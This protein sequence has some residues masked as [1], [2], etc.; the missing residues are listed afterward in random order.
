MSNAQKALYAQISAMGAPAAQQLSTNDGTGLDYAAGLN[1]GNSKNVFTRQDFVQDV[2]DY[3]YERDGKTFNTVDEA[4][5][6]FM[7]D[8]RWRN[9]NL[10]SIGRD[11]YDANTQNDEQTTRL[12]RLQTTFDAMP[13]FY[14]D[15]G[16]GWQ[17]FGTNALATLADPINL[18]GFGSG[19]IAAREAAKQVIAKGGRTALT[20]A[21]AASMKKTAT[22][23]ALKSGVYKGAL[24]EG[25]ASGVAEG[26]LDAGIQ[27]RNTELG[28]QDGYSLTQG[29]MA[30]GGG[31]L[32]GGG[33]GAVLGGVAAVAPNPFAKGRSATEMGMIDGRS[34]ARA[35]VRAD[36]EVDEL[37]PPVVAP[38]AELTE[39]QQ[40]TQRLVDQQAAV[41][42][43]TSGT[44]GA[45]A[46]SADDLDPDTPTADGRMSGS[47]VDALDLGEEDVLDLAAQQAVNLD[48]LAS[49]LDAE[50]LKETKNLDKVNGLNE[51]AR[52]MRNA[53]SNISNRLQK[54]LSDDEIT[55]PDVIQEI[56][57][58]TDQTNKD[59]KLIGYDS[60]AAQPTGNDGGGTVRNKT[61]QEKVDD[62]IDTNNEGA[63]PG[64]GGLLSGDE[65]ADFSDPQGFNSNGTLAGRGQSV[66]GD[67][68]EG[69]PDNKMGPQR[70]DQDLNN[71]DAEF[72]E[73][74]K[75]NQGRKNAM[76]DAVAAQEAVIENK[77]GSLFTKSE[78][79]MEGVDRS[80][81]VDDAEMSSV[82]DGGGLKPDTPPEVRKRFRDKFAGTDQTEEDVVPILVESRQRLMAEQNSLRDEIAK[83]QAILDELKQR[84]L[85]N[86]K[87]IDTETSDYQIKRDEA[88]AARA[89]AEENEAISFAAQRVEAEEIEGQRQAD[90]ANPVKVFEAFKGNNDVLEYLESI[91]ISDAEIAAYK[92]VDGRTAAK[93]E[94]F[95]EVFYRRM[96]EA[97]LG[98]ILHDLTNGEGVINA[99]FNTDNIPNTDKSFLELHLEGASPE[100]IKA[101][102]D[103]QE[104]MLS[105]PDLHT[106]KITEIMEGEVPEGEGGFFTAASN[107]YGPTFARRLTQRMKDIADA[108][109]SDETMP[110]PQRQMASPSGE[111][112]WG[113]NVK[114]GARALASGNF[115]TEGLSDTDGRFAHF[116][117]LLDDTLN[118]ELLNFK[119]YLLQR[120]LDEG[121]DQ[122]KAEKIASALYYEKLDKMAAGRDGFVERNEAML[123]GRIREI[124]D[125][126]ADLRTA[127]EAYVGSYAKLPVKYRSSLTQE[128]G[129]IM[130]R[131]ADG[132]L[133]E[134]ETFRYNLTKGQQPSSAEQKLI[135]AHYVN[136]A[137]LREV[138]GRYAKTSNAK[139][140]MKGR[141]DIPIGD[142]IVAA[143]TEISRLNAKKDGTIKIVSRGMRLTKDTSVHEDTGLADYMGR[144][145]IRDGQGIY[146]PNGKIQGILKKVGAKGFSG[147]L[148]RTGYKKDAKGQW[149]KQL[150]GYAHLDEMNRA[151]IE[152]GTQVRMRDE[153]Q[154]VRNKDRIQILDYH[155]ELIDSLQRAVSTLRNKDG[156]ATYKFKATKSKDDKG[157]KITLTEAED[158]L[159][160]ASQY[161]RNNIAEV[162]AIN[163]SQSKTL[164]GGLKGERTDLQSSTEQ[165]KFANEVEVDSQNRGA[166]LIKKANREISNRYAALLKQ[167]AG[168]KAVGKSLTRDDIDYMN[169]LFSMREQAN[170][171]TAH[172]QRAGTEV[173]Q[174][175]ANAIYMHAFTKQGKQRAARRRYLAEVKDGMY[176]YENSTYGEQDP[177]YEV[178]VSNEAAAI[179]FNERSNGKD[180]L[181]A[182]GNA[183]YDYLYGSEPTPDQRQQVN[184]QVNQLALTQA[185]KQEM[186]EANKT[187]M[188]RAQNGELT[189]AELLDAMA[190][191]NQQVQDLSIVKEAPTKPVGVKRQPLIATTPSGVEVD[192]NNDI[193]Y[194]R[195][196]ADGAIRLEIDGKELGRFSVAKNGNASIQHPDGFK[197][198]F[199]TA[200]D[201]K[202]NLVRI[203]NRQIE[204][205]QLQSKG[206]RFAVKKSA[207]GA[208][209][210][211]VD[212]TKTETYKNETPTKAET[213]DS[214]PEENPPVKNDP[215]NVLTWTAADFDDLPDGRQL[216][217]Q[218]LDVG[219]KVKKAGIVR[220]A[221]MKGT[222][223]SRQPQNIGD[224]LGLS[225]DVKYVIGHVQAGG[226]RSTAQETFFPM[227]L[228]DVFL[229]QN[230]NGL[231]GHDVPKGKRGMSA[232]VQSNRKRENRASKLED[233]Q[234]NELKLTD[235]DRDFFKRQG[236]ELNFVGDLVNYVERI[237]TLDWQGDIKTLAGLKRYATAR[238]AAARV[239][240]SN[241]PNG[242]KKPT[243][244][245]GFA[246]NKLRSMFDGYPQREVQTAVDFLERMAAYNGGR[247]PVLVKSTDG[248]AFDPNT[249]AIKVDVGSKDATKERSSPMA[250]ELVHEMG[251]W[252]YDNLLDEGDRQKFWSSMEKFYDDNGALDF[253]M[254][255]R[256]MVDK[257]LISNA[258]TNPQEFFANQFLGYVLQTDALRVPGSKLSEVFHKVSKLGKALFDY[259]MGRK[260]MSVDADLAD[261]FKK[262]L[263]EEEI[264]PLTGA[265]TR[266]LSKF[267]GLEQMGIEHG[268]DAQFSYG[269]DVM[270]AAQFAARQMVALDERIRDLQISKMASPRGLGD[271]FALAI[272]LEKIAK[273]LY[274]EYGGVKGEA[275]HKAIPGNPESG[276]ARI[277]ALDY[278]RSKT[279]GKTILEDVM[280]A[281]Y[282]IHGFLKRLRSE[283]ADSKVGQ[284]LSGQN[285]TDAAQAEAINREMTTDTARD[286]QSLYERMLTQSKSAYEGLDEAVVDQLHA[287]S[288]DL[289]VAMQRA[290]G[291]Y[292]GMFKRTMPRTERKKIAI[293]Q[294]TGAAYVET[295]PPKSAMFRNAAI[296][297]NRKVMAIEQSVSE[298]VEELSKRGID[299][300]DV[301]EDAI[302]ADAN[303]RSKNLI[304]AEEL[305]NAL[306]NADL[307]EGADNMGALAQAINELKTRVTFTT[308]D[309]SKELA[310]LEADDSPL[311][312]ILR[313]NDEALR[314]KTMAALEADPSDFNLALLDYGR[315]H[316]ATVPDAPDPISTDPLNPAI[317]TFADRISVR[318]MDKTE[319]GI[320]R[321]LF[322]KLVR[323]IKGA[324][325][326]Q[327]ILD[328]SAE[329]IN[330]F[331]LAILRGD[332]LA[333]EYSDETVVLPQGENYDEA[334]RS[335]RGMAKEITKINELRNVYI[336]ILDSKG[337][338]AEVAPHR[339]A[340]FDSLYNITFAM[341]SRDEQ[342]GIMSLEKADK[343]NLK[344]KFSRL[345][346]KSVDSVFV[347]VA[348][349]TEE[350]ASADMPYLFQTAQTEA[351]QFQIDDAVQI[352]DGMLLQP[353]S[354]KE[355]KMEVRRMAVADLHKAKRDKHEILGMVINPEGVTL[356]HPS[357]AGKYT[358]S[359]LDNV[360]PRLDNAIRDFV[361]LR[362]EASLRDS[363]QYNVSVDQAVR[364]VTVT[365]NGRYGEGVYL[366][367][368]KEVDT[369]YSAA[370]IKK[371]VEDDMFH[372]DAPKN[373]APDIDS[374]MKDIAFYREQIR[375]LSNKANPTFD[376]RRL[377]NMTLKMERS[378]WDALSRLT[379]S[380][381]TKVAP[382]FARIRAPLDVSSKQSYSLG[383]EED[384]SVR[385]IIM[386]LADK[387]I[388]D[389]DGVT[390]AV[391]RFIEPV[392]G[393]RMYDAFTNGRDGLMVMSGTA[394][395]QA[396]A[397]AKFK[398]ILKDLG[399]DAMHTDQGDVV[400]DPSM[401]KE[402]NSFEATDAL[403]FDGVGFGGD[404]K[405]TGQVVEEMMVKNAPLK[406][407]EFVGV[408]REVR[409]MGVPAPITKITK[410]I[411]NQHKIEGDDVQ[412]ISTWSTVKNFFREN[413][414]LMRQLGANWFGDQIKP[415]NGVGTFEKHDA[416]LAR[417]LQPIIAKLNDLPDAGNNFQRWNRRN[418][419]LAM[420]ALDVG[421]PASH[422]RV[423]QALRRGRGAVAKLK[424]AEQRVAMEIGNAFND[425]FNKMK[426]LGIKVG[427]ARKLG[428][429]FYVPQIWD[430]E[431][432][433]ANPKKFQLGLSEFLRR[434]Q[435]DPDFDPNDRMTPTEL[436][437]LADMIASKLTRGSDPTVDGDL[438]AAMSNNPF[439]ARVLALKPGDYDF[440]DG[441]LVQDLQGILAKYYDRTIRKRVL[442]EQFGVNA[443][444]FTAYV[445]IADGGGVKEA[446]NILKADYNPNDTVSTE[447]GSAT[448][449][450]VMINR[451]TLNPD[452]TKEL[453]RRLQRMLGD[454]KT[455]INNKQAAI[456]MLMEMGDADATRNVQY[457]KRVEAVVNGLIDFSQGRPPSTTIAKMRAMMNVLNK[458]PIDGG[459]GTE[460]RYKVSRLL[461]SFTSVSLLGFTTFTSIPDV[462]LP[463]VRS[464]NMRAFA[465][466]WAKYS[467]DPSYRAAAKN[468]GVGIDNLMHERMV[469][470]S[471]EG[472]QKFANAFF[473]LTL[474]TPW[475]N[476]MREV[477]SLVG[478]ESFKSEIDRAMR[479]KRK[480]K[481]DSR[482]Y[483][484][485]VRY[486]ERYGLT[487]E[488]APHDF[489]VDGSFRID[490]LPK[491]EAVQMQV[492]MAMMRFTNEA[493]FTPNPNDV[494]M[495]AQ[496]P[497]GSMMF[498]LKS[499]PMLMMKLQGYI[500]DEFKQGN[501]APLAYMLT[502]G[503]GAG[504]IS[505][506]VKDFVQMRGGDEENSADFRKRSL[507]KDREK[508]GEVLGLKEGDD[509]DAAL[510][511]YLDGLLAV[512][513]MG[514]IGEMLYNTSA[515]L[516][517]GKYGFVRT[518]SGVFGPQVG[519]AELGFNAV[520]GAGQ[521]TSNFFSDEKDKPNDKIRATLR[522][523]FGRIPIAGRVYGGPTGRETFVDAVGGEAKKPGRKKGSGEGK[524]GDGFGS[525]DFNSNKFGGKFD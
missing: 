491:N 438:Q 54:F 204:E 254:L 66:V 262:F 205:I 249:N 361:G 201:L 9:M 425:E 390:A 443:H 121:Y 522:D 357:V 57:L 169:L 253:D 466:T 51:R 504:S 407:A 74:L 299:W 381:D 242:I 206:E 99:A 190:R 507:V 139:V 334:R 307:A 360:S 27:A 25:A 451:L 197:V 523:L 118:V 60:D 303:A 55:T 500:M 189:S 89:I 3:Y 349:P 59:M 280:Q 124:K 403:L 396:D 268:K 335:L 162:G 279:G 287:L 113:M 337:Y 98:R 414:S 91:G 13:D 136:L 300:R 427:D 316:G 364:G 148:V 154:A 511:W 158:R 241:V 196:K 285:P 510:G 155:I 37:L 68:I 166:T 93:K 42:A 65:A 278:A 227:N 450:D 156:G 7:E 314:T 185:A 290:V 296:K 229:D 333:M 293:D 274:G 322:I 265:P 29:A 409:R 405:L 368:T 46:L 519:T 439:A 418:R 382:V 477:A 127:R 509:V 105:N 165:Q 47:D 200:K 240:K 15:G 432:I 53:S 21:G 422:T 43:R 362:P 295:L 400:F 214:S 330:E 52:K 191:L 96:G 110:L 220:Q 187:L 410:K 383:A 455:A 470:M 420:G 116:Q 178:D 399:Y 85:D 483:K 440:M 100:I 147:K 45:A 231:I 431:A 482:S 88:L 103:A 4:K 286:V 104:R 179:E 203:F 516:D 350:F 367:S 177:N 198:T 255:S 83:E 49:E 524:F 351:L 10:V 76:D 481:T 329:T 216:A 69:G 215:E 125:G 331:D 327:D 517:N 478:V 355:R 19:G 292:A 424:P 202:Q 430:S 270:P 111:K 44:R 130:V 115:A 146:E 18:L 180:Q 282:K 133:V 473:N 251:H 128:A 212:H 226:G 219:G 487:G 374:A 35:T 24:Y 168:L 306:H 22:K 243:T 525:S 392:S 131:G 137:K 297:N 153:I 218:F 344:A 489:L 186:I 273:S 366:V 391:D 388:L 311:L 345:S 245:I 247:A 109:L 515:Q 385:H 373:S 395:S 257:S 140:I 208:P 456:H 30:V 1:K 123:N 461:K 23:A 171:L 496:T 172:H 272:E 8:R 271:S 61:V 31:A 87:V 252:I 284:S 363:F 499:F 183:A 82:L 238:A 449:T 338:D 141:N 258:A 32:I 150:A 508:L 211:Q 343:D 371:Q 419:G 6:Y 416:M 239:L 497:W 512:G 359:Y 181:G 324:E 58:I 520:A 176:D 464:G 502:A 117:T 256:G 129:T 291:E 225:S 38:E 376:E 426:A 495:W 41:N 164:I 14:E 236:E 138:R 441:F 301:G 135:S 421:Q 486:L 170:K 92:K 143:D 79:D 101:T 521:A 233:V 341:R 184:T 317:K 71:D 126:I 119:D 433:L 476:T 12:A 468:I 514:L 194:Y 63:R 114:G 404:M 40:I 210:V 434:S 107:L 352:L 75:V 77:S 267:A 315:K 97:Q 354:M 62:F 506:G 16:D 122:P 452:E 377:L 188:A 81:G 237:E 199:S 149:Q 437:E 289:Q 277:Q 474:L 436:G 346:T 445:D 33:M 475:T 457:A 479:L 28:L 375:D 11:L 393:P 108:K 112:P 417:R 228:D 209:H 217:V 230:G 310:Q 294:Y 348:S 298:I 288:S 250:M 222:G 78:F 394:K 370:Q 224:M 365:K 304:S 70:P 378:R 397:Q 2:Y 384:G 336:N 309:S 163:R 48:R 485:A 369:N 463:L 398:K 145:Q 320:A 266:G 490:T 151:K 248:P 106:A 283:E 401:V 193:K 313:G 428:S 318:G 326:P 503:V 276:S 261:L 192:L 36:A 263:P 319:Q 72:A 302:L 312:A 167:E 447:S 412:K 20:A 17:G 94:K 86:D 134:M 501:V 325:D 275:F 498:Q 175:K 207:E 488:N 95:V 144:S 480:G 413:S 358:N 64:D 415:M 56:K 332:P 353:Q 142:L 152:R 34:Q 39:A 50:A 484:T 471:G 389:A 465:K 469:H 5:D 160:A 513:G 402:A 458:K 462:A 102:L 356:V 454:P 339:K 379:N 380:V 323:K 442:T 411:F 518:M 174:K 264:D 305:A 26:I 90:K 269:N 235:A 260:T 340:L 132:N 120:S 467:T 387:K 494:P 173:D 157:I 328:E 342:Q 459:D 221:G 159:F 195:Q 259:L 448:V 80:E 321:D 246:M 213:V 347:E 453:I 386:E 472:N 223:D 182:E 492:Q 406:N 244:T 446:V 161:A 505:V 73:R 460:A 234:G 372:S 281:Q 408:A 67:P 493:I 308:R 423:I 444:A 232:K 435:L 84:R 429:D